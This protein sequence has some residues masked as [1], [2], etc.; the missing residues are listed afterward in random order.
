MRPDLDGIPISIEAALPLFFR[1][2]QTFQRFRAWR[3]TAA[4][5]HGRKLFAYRWFV[6]FVAV[7]D[8]RTERM[9]E[10]HKLAVVWNPIPD[11]LVACR[12]PVIEH[13]IRRVAAS[14]AFH[15]APARTQSDGAAARERPRSEPK[16]RPVRWE[17]N[18]SNAA[19]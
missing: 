14:Q 19:S 5:W 6:Q 3:L 18:R 12:I 1:A 15:D 9:P 13:E 17:P 7:I 2:T 11:D 10:R 16:G 8:A 4:P